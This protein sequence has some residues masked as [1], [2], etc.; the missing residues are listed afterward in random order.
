MVISLLYCSQ[1]NLVQVGM[2]GS[3]TVNTRGEREVSNILV[4]TYMNR[5]ARK[6]ATD[7]V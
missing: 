1:P 6:L 5:S 2:T 4:E 3:I 7:K